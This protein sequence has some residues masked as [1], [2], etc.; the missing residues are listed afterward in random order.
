MAHKNS[1]TRTS[2][3]FVLKCERVMVLR[4]KHLA[5]NAPS[6]PAPIKHCRILEVLELTPISHELQDPPNRDSNLAD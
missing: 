1:E 3:A 5:N 6:Q 2:L 4:Q